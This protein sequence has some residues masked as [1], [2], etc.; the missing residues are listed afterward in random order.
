MVKLRT[1]LRSV[2][3]SRP[4]R[5]TSLID[6]ESQHLLLSKQSCFK[7]SAR[8]VTTVGLTLI[9]P[10]EAAHSA[11]GISPKVLRNQIGPD[12]MPS[13]SLRRILDGLEKSNQVKVFKGIN[14]G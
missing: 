6:A 10:N 2:C 14:V 7:R 11:L 1:T 4:G 5:D 8:L 3:W 9:A 13:T 12:V